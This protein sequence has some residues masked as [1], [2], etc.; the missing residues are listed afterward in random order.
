MSSSA[1]T[2]LTVDPQAVVENFQRLQRVAAGAVTAA[3]VK[4]DAYGMGVTLVAPA[5]AN[6]GCADFFVATLDEALQLRGLVPRARIFVLGGFGMAAPADF[7]ATDLVPVLNSLGEIEQARAAAV[8][9]QRPITAAIH[10]DTGM[11][12]LG[13]TVAHAEALAREPAALARLDLALMMSHFACADEQDHP[14]IATQIERFAK[15]RALFPRVK[16]SLAASSG[17]FRGAEARFDIVRP[18]AALYGI[19]PTREVPNPMVPVCR[20]EARVLQVRE[21]MA[22]ETIGYGATYRAAA[23]MRIATVAAGYADGV[24]RSLG[25]LGYA[26]AGGHRLPIVGRVSMDL[27]TVDL[28]ALSAPAIQ[29][30]DWVTLLGPERPVDEVAAE[31]GTIGYEILA[32]IAPRAVRIAGPLERR[33]A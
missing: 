6:A 1:L 27:I 4:A 21:I 20:L 18:G 19:N 26:H 10:I 30:G 5:L 24:L 15:V 16:A 2:R 12:R 25:N 11:N 9:A 7:L 29:P 8:R 3:V 32:R 17:I 22:G 33:S 14:M 28:S 23:P 31:A 13:L